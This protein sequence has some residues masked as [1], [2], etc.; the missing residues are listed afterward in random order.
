MCYGHTITI[1]TVTARSPKGKAPPPSTAWH[2]L[3]FVAVAAAAVATRSADATLAGTAP[4]PHPSALKN[5]TSLFS[6]ICHHPRLNCSLPAWLP[7]L[8]FCRDPLRSSGHMHLLQII[9]VLTGLG[10]FIN[11]IKATKGG[12]TANSDSEGRLRYSPL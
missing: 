6:C 4:S 7:L 11:D 2:D 8:S 5:L 10:V 9:V 3:E 12:Y 1:C